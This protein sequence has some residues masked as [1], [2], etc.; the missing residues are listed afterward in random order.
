MLTL[1]VYRLRPEEAE[2]VV[3][4]NRSLDEVDEL[5][6]DEGLSAFAPLPLIVPNVIE[7]GGHWDCLWFLLSGERQ[8]QS[9]SWSNEMAD[10][11]SWVVA[12]RLPT[13]TSGR[14]EG[15]LRRDPLDRLRFNRPVDVQAAADALRMFPLPI[16]DVDPAAVRKAGVYHSRACPG[17]PGGLDAGVFTRAI[18]GL[19][20]FYNAS[21][22]IG[23]STIHFL[24]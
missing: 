9:A 5:L 24:G 7:L 2:A 19:K 3:R 21:A 20:R 11:L 16:Q 18:Q 22:E 15:N 17:V 6:G 8:A 1:E 12:G 14:R 23:D 4:G 10:P 13:E